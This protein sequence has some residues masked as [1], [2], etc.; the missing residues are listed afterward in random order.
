MCSSSCFAFSSSILL[1]INTEE[2]LL[3]RA[4]GRRPFGDDNLHGSRGRRVE[5]CNAD[6]ARVLQSLDGATGLVHSLQVKL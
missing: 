3:S 4:D 5:G 2:N 1:S 6:A